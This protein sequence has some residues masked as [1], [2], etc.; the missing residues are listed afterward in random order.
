MWFNFK[1]VLNSHCTQRVQCIFTAFWR[2]VAFTPPPKCHSQLCWIR[3][4]TTVSLPISV[5]VPEHQPQHRPCTHHAHAARGTRR[6]CCHVSQ[7]WPHTL[8]RML[9]SAYWLGGTL[10]LLKGDNI[11]YGSLKLWWGWKWASRTRTGHGA[12]AL[13]SKFTRL[14][15]LGC[16]SLKT[17]ALWGLL[18]KF[19]ISKCYLL[20]S[21]QT[22]CSQ[23]VVRK[24]GWFVG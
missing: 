7:L 1:N 9:G 11:S 18:L 10:L 5:H 15:A 2:K 16:I 24:L 13:Y 19:S 4:F 8:Q 21:T 14:S 23:K 22:L 17:G 12:E 6:S 3:G 20:F